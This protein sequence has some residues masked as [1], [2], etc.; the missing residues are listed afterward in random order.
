[1]KAPWNARRS[2]IARWGS[3][4]VGLVRPGAEAVLLVGVAIGCAQIGW[5]IAAPD[6]PTFSSEDGGILLSGAAD[7][8]REFRTPFAPL[9]A[10]AAGEQTPH[11]DIA[12]FRL[13]GLRLSTIP[14]QSGAVLTLGDGVQRSFLVGYQIAEGVRLEEVAANHIVVSI[15]DREETLALEKPA[16]TPSLALALMGRPQMA[17]EASPPVAL[18]KAGEP[19]SRTV[20][21]PVKAGADLA[22]WLFATAGQVETR[23]GA[24]YGWRVASG[25]P[26]ADIRPGDVVISVNG[27]GPGDSKA[28]L[29]SAANGP[30]MLVVERR[31]GERVRLSLSSGVGP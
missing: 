29:L 4:A 5:R 7:A 30:V 10:A 23:N 12:G 16:R 14:E 31:S 25:L 22:D 20:S 2:L 3:G 11:A 24:P 19:E 6:S 18:A 9:G 8:T 26:A 15:G 21:L 1:M 28:A 17:P 13:V 27:S